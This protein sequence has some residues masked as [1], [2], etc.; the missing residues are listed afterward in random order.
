MTQVSI[1]SFTFIPCHRIE[2][3]SYFPKL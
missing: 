3:S 2:F 1:Q